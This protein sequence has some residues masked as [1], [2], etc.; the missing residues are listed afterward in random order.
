MLD[1]ITATMTL[2]IIGVFDTAVVFYF[3]GCTADVI[4]RDGP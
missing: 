2:D 4:T 1:H 3:L